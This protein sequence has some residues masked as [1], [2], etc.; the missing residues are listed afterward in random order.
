MRKHLL[1]LVIILGFSIN[2]NAQCDNALPIS[3]DFSNTFAVNSCWS[4]IDYDGDGLGWSI[5]SLDGSGNK[6]LKSKSFAGTALTPDNW[7]IYS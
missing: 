5:T 2:L 4:Y 3:E 1:L 6:G 7:I